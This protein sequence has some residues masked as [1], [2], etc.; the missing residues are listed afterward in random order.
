MCVLAAVV[1]LAA[2]GGGDGGDPLASFKSQKL[3]WQSCD[4]QILGD[5]GAA[6]LN[7]FNVTL[8]QFGTRLSCATMRAPLDYANPSKGELQVA[9]MRVAAEDPAQR[10]GAIMFNPGGPGGDG[11]ILAPVFGAM[12]SGANEQTTTGALYKQMARSFD[13]VG[14]SPRGMGAST[15]LSCS[16]SE[17][18][19]FV[20][21]ETAD[22]TPANLAAMLYNARLTAE[23][24]ARNPLTPYINTDATARD[25]DL[26][27]H[28]LGDE[29]LNYYGISYGTWLGT[30]Y[31][32]LFPERVGRMVLSGVVN[33]Q[34]SLAMTFLAQPMGYQR[35]FDQVILPYAARHAGIFSLDGSA[36]SLGTVFAA[37]DVNLQVA[38][39]QMVTG[40][41]GNAKNATNVVLAV[42]AGK[43]L[44]GLLKAVDVQALLNAGN[45]TAAAALV[46][47]RIAT[48][49]FAQTP[50]LNGQRYDLNATARQLAL[51]L[52]SGFFEQVNRV[53]G[54][55]NDVGGEALAYAVPSNDTAMGMD[56]DAWMA[57]TNSNALNYSLAGGMFTNWPGLYWGAPSVTR[58]PLERAAQAGA[59]VMLQT[60]LDAQ[61]PVEGAEQSLTA[62]PNASIVLIRNDYTHGPM[63]PYGQ[64]CVDDPVARYFLSGTPMPRRTECD[65]NAL[66]WDSLQPMTAQ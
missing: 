27:R 38:V 14:F 12:W 40:Y 60:S 6:I 2:C 43:K 22:R 39:S 30:W 10:K 13:L 33:Q 34:Q 44:D 48:T 29:K 51:Q 65:G 64:S 36:A 1:Q 9:F 19:K 42:V 5:S 32:S 23:A 55:V 58:P 57:A 49:D 28:L 15:R 11:L 3:I 46:N 37:L 41:L 52:A 26:M 62:L 50:T 59:I 31:A 66:L 56:I 7:K 47:E 54:P 4:P 24:C 8:E 18:K 53:T 35:A 16:S 61:T 17:T 20:A 45:T 63:L 21:N 25:M